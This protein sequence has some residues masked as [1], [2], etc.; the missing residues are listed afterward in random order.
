MTRK[1][2]PGYPCSCS[3]CGERLRSS[4]DRS[5][6]SCGDLVSFDDLMR[7]KE[8]VAPVPSVSRAEE[9]KRCKELRI[10]KKKLRKI[11]KIE[12]RN[13][14]IRRTEICKRCVVYTD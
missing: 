10:S 11:Q 6:H 7:G 5:G 3:I 2:E 14:Y 8:F 13:E 12:R 4:A 9:T 1:R